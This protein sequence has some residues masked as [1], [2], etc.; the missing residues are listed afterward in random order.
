VSLWRCGWSSSE[1]SSS[2][3]LLFGSASVIV[4]EVLVLVKTGVAFKIVAG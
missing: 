4:L 1:S 2:S 3:T